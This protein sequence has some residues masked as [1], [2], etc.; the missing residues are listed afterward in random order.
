VGV[1]RR[2]YREGQLSKDW[3]L[4]YRVNGKRHKRRIGPNKKLAD[5]VVM[6][7]EAKKAK[8]EYLGVGV[9]EVKKITVADFLDTST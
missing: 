8:G 1:F 7:I 4:D 3:Y 9:H 2:R 5:Q 6:D